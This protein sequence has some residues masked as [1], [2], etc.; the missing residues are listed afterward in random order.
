MDQGLLIVFAQLPDGA[1]L[2]R[3]NDVQ[4]QIAE[5]GK[6]TPGLD[7]TF[8]IEGLSILDSTT[9]SN[10]LTFWMP[11]KPFNE[12]IGHPEQSATAIATKLQSAF[13]SLQDAFVIAILPPSGRGMWNPVRF[14]PA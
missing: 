7:L 12:R 5:I 3:T 8:A 6:N 4:R 1:S 13:S 2:Q 10:A 11:L 14:Q 9:K